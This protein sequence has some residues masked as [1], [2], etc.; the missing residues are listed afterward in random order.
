MAS[1]VAPWVLNA[2]GG[3]PVGHTLTLEKVADERVLG[4]GGFALTSAAFQNG[5]ELDP[6]FTAIEEDAVAPPL[7]WTSPPPGAQ[8]IVLVAEDADKGHVHWTVWGLP[9]QKG[10]LMEGETPPR[11]GKNAH[12]NSE[13]LLPDPPLGEEH[14][15]VFQL[16][17]IETIL[18][19]AT[20]AAAFVMISLFSNILSTGFLLVFGFWLVSY[21]ICSVIAYLA[22]IAGLILHYRFGLSIFY[23]QTASVTL[24]AVV[25]AVVTA[26]VSQFM[27]RKNGFLFDDLVMPLMILF[28]LTQWLLYAQHRNE[29]CFSRYSK[30]MQSTNLEQFIPEKLRGE[31]IMIEAQDHYVQVTTDKGQQLLR[32]RFKDA[33]ERGSANT[34]ILVHRS[35]GVSMSAF[36]AYSDSG[37]K[38]ILTLKNGVEVPVSTAHIDH[39]Q[40]IINA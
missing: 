21:L 27:L 34:G 6:S 32:M 20:L 17:A 2:V 8:E 10:K 16:F 28:V 11:T 25:A 12:G 24:A 18:V 39:G 30:R 3:V 19:V 35:Y 31:I 38:P 26:Q 4:R 14:R 22:T 7:E 9:P 40:R 5:G 36:K 15:Y 13:W 37:E 1:G 33:I 29:I 23:I